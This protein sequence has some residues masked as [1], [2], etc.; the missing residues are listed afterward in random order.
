MR[1]TDESRLPGVQLVPLGLIRRPHWRHDRKDERIAAEGQLRRRGLKE[2]GRCHHLLK[3]TEEPERCHRGPK[4]HQ[5]YP[6]SK[7]RELDQLAEVGESSTVCAE[8]VELTKPANCAKR[9]GQ[10]ASAGRSPLA[11]PATGA[12]HCH[13]HQRRVTDSN[14]PHPSADAQS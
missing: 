1:N 9:A 2:R 14:R 13:R 4:T 11:V 10:L 5:R 7:L 3:T 8:S 12:G 6:T